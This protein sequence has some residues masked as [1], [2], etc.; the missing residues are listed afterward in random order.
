MKLAIAIDRNPTSAARSAWTDADDEELFV[1]LGDQD[2]LRK[3]RPTEPDST[4]SGQELS[5]ALK[6]RYVFNYPAFREY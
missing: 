2:R 3:L 1:T 4:L 5:A 6:E